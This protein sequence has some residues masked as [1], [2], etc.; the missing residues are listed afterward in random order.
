MACRRDK[1][2]VV[3]FSRCQDWGGVGS[4]PEAS[5]LDALE[6]DLVCSP[7]FPATQVEDGAHRRRRRVRSEGAVVGGA[8]HDLT[9]VD[10]SNDDA[11]F[12]VS[13]APARPSRRL[14][15][16]PESV[17]ATPQSIQ[18]REWVEPTVSPVRSVV[19]PKVFPMSDSK[20]C[21]ICCGA[22]RIALQEIV[23]GS[24]AHNEDRQCRGWK[25][26]LFLPRMLFRPPR[27]GL[28]PRHRPIAGAVCNVCHGP[29]DAIVDFESG[30]FG[31]RKA[32]I[33]RRR[34]HV[35]SPEKRAERAQML[36]LMGEVSAGRQAL[37]GAAVA[38][39]TQAT[40]NQLRQRPLSPQGTVASSVD[41][42]RKCVS[43][44]SRHFREEFE[45]RTKRSSWRDIRGDS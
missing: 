3:R 44:G 8:I 5:L 29:V 35:D 42:F 4:E 17:D 19:A 30:E 1:A 32:T 26:F 36:V 24:E 22:M 9:L 45:V 40:L 43:V 27:G 11:P 21:E 23:E 25:L 6:Q 33:R 37:D 31:A 20:S 2:V 41:A 18:D 16:V 7:D 14:V 12:V 15:L 13:A 10:S 39:G 38:A 34:T 28:I